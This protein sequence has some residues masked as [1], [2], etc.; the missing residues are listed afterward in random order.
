M[1]S[2][3][4][5]A[6]PTEPATPGARVYTQGRYWVATLGP[7]LLLGALLALSVVRIAS[8]AEAKVDRY[9]IVIVPIVLLVNILGMRQPRRIIDTPECLVLEGMGRRQVFRGAP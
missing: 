4:D 7:L 9:V 1:R 8:G 5:G 2:R 3:G 6:G